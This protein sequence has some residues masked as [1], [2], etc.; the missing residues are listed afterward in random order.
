MY[1]FRDKQKCI[2]GLAFLRPLGCSLFSVSVN[3]EVPININACYA[4]VLGGEYTPKP[5]YFMQITE[6]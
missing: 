5:N 4:C 1:I 3:T 2:L 6:L